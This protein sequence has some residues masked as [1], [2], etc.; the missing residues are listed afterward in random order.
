MATEITS[1]LD[2]VVFYVS[3]IQA[4]L[5]YFTEQL[6][7]THVVEESSET[8]HTLTGNNGFNFGIN[9]ASAQT[10]AAG[11]VEIYFKPGDFVGLHSQLVAQTNQTG[12]ITHMPF[13]T[14][15]TSQTPDNAKIVVM[16]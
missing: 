15:F 9:L 14:I 3:D 16:Q 8:F 5:A 7:L 10:P 12:P 11:T 2:F 1:Q 4:S 13:G 6:G